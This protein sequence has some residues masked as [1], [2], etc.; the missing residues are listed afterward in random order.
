MSEVINKWI[1]KLQ[2]T[3]L[4]VFAVGYILTKSYFDFAS[5]EYFIYNLAAL[6]VC[7]SL[8]YQLRK[9]HSHN[10]AAWLA[11]ILIVTVYYLRSY[12]I[13]LDPTPVKVMLPWN[14]YYDMLDR[15]DLLLNSF[16]L[17]TL[18]FV[19]FGFSIIFLFKFLNSHN[20]QKKTADEVPAGH[21]NFL[22]DILVVSL[23]L[24]ML[25]LYFL[26]YYFQIGL[27]GASS[28]DPLPFR[29]KGIIFYVNTVFIPLL[30]ALLIYLSERSN[31]KTIS[32]LGVLL[33][34]AHG[35]VLMVL[36]GSRSSLLLSI[37]LL[38]FLVLVGG[39]KL[40]RNQKILMAVFI[41]GAFFMVPVMTNYRSL[42]IEQAML[43]SEAISMAMHATYADWAGGIIQGLK[44]VLFRMPGIESLW[45]ML[46]QG[47][48]PLD[49]QL[50]NV[51][52]K[53][54][55]IAGYLTYN[56]YLL[57]PT[58][59]TLLA[60]GFV[61][62]FYL[63]GGSL[64]VALGGGVA[65]LLSVLSWVIANKEYLK[66]RV[67]A[68]MFLLWMLFLVLTEGTLDI[69]VMLVLSGLVCLAT[70][71][72]VLRSSASPIKLIK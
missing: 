70:I 2:W 46:A 50:F 30:V 26:T 22:A 15:R 56:I 68:Q 64:G 7:A 44:F 45:C 48:A 16:K 1:D 63:V 72:Y 21:S 58:D 17:S 5:G 28:G 18:M 54:N 3:L 60:P 43:V 71:E 29:L 53:K 33:M 36:R 38:I 52:D 69:M 27:M 6:G 51:L 4:L 65:A 40:Q 39:L 13:T 10:A 12:W 31:R 42:R 61:G 9:I 57:K 41:I 47:A 37:V 55:G 35:L 24:V 8:I 14:P 34:I 11:L 23:P 32:N 67:I 66:C 62:W 20:S 25:V 19:S 49:G 59:N